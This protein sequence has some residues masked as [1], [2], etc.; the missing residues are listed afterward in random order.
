MKQNDNI[1]RPSF[2]KQPNIVLTGDNAVRKPRTYLDQYQEEQQRR[3]EERRK[4]W[5]KQIHK[6]AV[7]KE[8][9]ERRARNSAFTLQEA[10]AI[11]VIVAVLFVSCAFYL[12]QLSSQYT[13]SRATNRLKSEYAQ[14]LQDNNAQS[15]Y[16]EGA[17]DYDYIYWY[18]T[19]ELGMSYPEKGQQI[20]YHRSDA[21]RVR[22]VED[23]PEE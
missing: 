12:T 9:Q 7:Q 14:L 3:Q 4:R 13:V 5:E 22:Q 17:I 18:A 8:F 16:I 20:T 2:G 15:S 19:R 23:I 6:R 10:C 11:A 21:S 1:I